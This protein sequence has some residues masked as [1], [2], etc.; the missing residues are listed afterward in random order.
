MELILPEDEFLAYEA[1]AKDVG[2]TISDVIRMK[3]KGFEPT[4]KAA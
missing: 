4:R 3:L 1:L 2:I